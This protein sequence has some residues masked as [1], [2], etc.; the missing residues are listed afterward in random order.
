MLGKPKTKR[1]HHY[2]LKRRRFQ[3]EEQKKARSRNEDGGLKE[4]KAMT[5]S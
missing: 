3:A 1:V 5:H 4:Q 2:K